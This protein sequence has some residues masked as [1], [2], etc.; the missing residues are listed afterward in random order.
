MSC[1]RLTRLKL[2]NA[3]LHLTSNVCQIQVQGHMIQAQGHMIDQDENL[4][5]MCHC[6]Q[7]IAKGI[8][9]ILICLVVVTEILNHAWP[10]NVLK[11]KKK[12]IFKL[13]KG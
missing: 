1:L 4:E 10:E 13:T 2:R 7:I 5:M 9:Y 11:R 8:L 6:R 3:R 12:D